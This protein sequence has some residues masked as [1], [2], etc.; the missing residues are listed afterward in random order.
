MLS[1]HT[2]C[3]KRIICNSVMLL[4]LWVIALWVLCGVRYSTM[5]GTAKYQ[6]VQRSTRHSFELKTNRP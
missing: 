1:H 6:E 4:S 2:F 5:D 3:Q